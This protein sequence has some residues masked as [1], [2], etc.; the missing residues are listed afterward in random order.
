MYPR[1]TLR[2]NRRLSGSRRQS[3]RLWLIAG[4]TCVPLLVIAYV[5]TLVGGE[6]ASDAAYVSGT[7]AHG[8]YGQN[9]YGQ[10]SGAGGWG[11]GG[12]TMMPGPAGSSPS[13]QVNPASPSSSAPSSSSLP[14]S[15][16]APSSPSSSSTPSSPPSSSSAGEANGTVTAATSENWAG[17]VAA[18]TVG[19]FATVSASWAEPTATCGASATFSSFWV[20]LDGAGTST[21]EQT[22]TE[23]D[24]AS[25]AASYQG[26][27]EMFPSAPVFYDNPVQP[28]D[29][30]SAS[31]VANGNGSFTL[32]LTD[33][34]QGWTQTT[35]QTSDTAQ[36]GSAEIIAEAPSDGQVL[37]LTDFGTVNF[38]DA[39]INNEAVGDSNTMAL[40]MDSAENVAEATPS[41]LTNGDDFTVTFDNADTTGTTGT[42]G[43]GGVGGA[44]G[45][46]GTGGGYQHRHHHHDDSGL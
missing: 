36:L 35:Q 23:A 13:Q 12:Y 10:T 11:R 9:P 28:G 4:A 21:V 44:G 18:G 1:R 34:T 22:G 43:T 39:L 41:A 37:P 14:S 5:L 26:W 6:S 32:T 17:Y 2:R 38:T 25:G 30:M 24:C 40:T 29:A 20:G 33:S 27:F 15:S 8:T 16:S 3:R 46:G 7:V 19:T 31:V 42:S 45:T